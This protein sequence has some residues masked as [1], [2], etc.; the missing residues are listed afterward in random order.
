[1]EPFFRRKVPHLQRTTIRKE[2]RAATTGYN[3][4][5]V[6]AKFLCY[7]VASLFLSL[8]LLIGEADCGTFLSEKGSTPPKN[9]KKEREKSSH[10]RI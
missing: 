8:C 4:V 5:T 2:K 9:Y 3:T 6:F 1:V 10:N 7:R